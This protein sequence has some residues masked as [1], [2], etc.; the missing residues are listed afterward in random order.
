MFNAVVQH[1]SLKKCNFHI[2]K[3]H[4]AFFLLKNLYFLWDFVIE[5]IDLLYLLVIACATSRIYIKQKAN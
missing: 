1:G 3:L 2:H 5:T 4:K